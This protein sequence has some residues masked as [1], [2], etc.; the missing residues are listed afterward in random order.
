MKEKPDAKLCVLYQN[1]DFG[2]DYLAGLHEAFGAGFDKTVVTGCTGVAARGDIR[3][4][5]C[6]L[7]DTRPRHDRLAPFGGYGLLAP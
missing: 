6:R 5:S 1:D 7:G 4:L 2:K 3:A